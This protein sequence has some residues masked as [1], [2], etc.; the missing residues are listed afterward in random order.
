MDRGSSW[1]I[2]GLGSEWKGD[3][4]FRGG[5]GLMELG[6]GEGVKRDP[7]GPKLEVAQGRVER[8][9]RGPWRPG[10]LGWAWLGSPGGDP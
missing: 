1:N 8:R 9:P 2:P 6:A 7:A 10:T 5:R 4:L 3:P